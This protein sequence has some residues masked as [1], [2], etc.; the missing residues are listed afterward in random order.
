MLVVRS[1]SESACKVTSVQLKQSCKKEQ[2]ASSASRVVVVARRSS[3]CLLPTR[4][5]M[6]SPRL[7]PF[8]ALRPLYTP[9]QPRL[10]S[11]STPPT[12][13]ARRSL[14]DIALVGVAGAS[15]VGWMV[16][17]NRAKEE[18]ILEGDAASFTVP[19]LAQCV[20][21]PPELPDQG[22]ACVTTA[23]EDGHG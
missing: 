3:L 17:R 1:L 2:S 12:P 16:W 4:R 18:E 8:A 20:S 19:V 10:R 11:Y 9:L 6:P 23:G 15:A 22:G 5:A 13:V 21:S 14:V 7:R